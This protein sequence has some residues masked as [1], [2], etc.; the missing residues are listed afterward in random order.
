MGIP[1]TPSTHR[2]SAGETL[3]KL[4]QRYKTTVDAFVKANHIPNP[5]LI[6]VG[7]I[8]KIPGTGTSQKA[9]PAGTSPSAVQTVPFNFQ[10]LSFLQQTSTV[11]EEVFKIEGQ[12]YVFTTSNNQTSIALRSDA[13]CFRFGQQ[14]KPVWF[15]TRDNGFPLFA[16]RPNKLDALLSDPAALGNAL[17]PAKA[18]APFRVFTAKQMYAYE[19][20]FQWFEPLADHYRELIW[21]HPGTETKSSPAYQAYK[22][23]TWKDIVDFSNVDRWSISYGRKNEGDWKHNKKDGADGFLLVSLEGYPYWADAIGQ[24]PFAVD[25]YKSNL[26]ELG[27]KDKAILQTV[28]TGIKHGDGSIFFTTKDPT[29]NYDNFMVLRGALWAANNHS[30]TKTETEVS[31]GYGER[32]TLT[33]ISVRYQ[34]RDMNDLKK[35]ITHLPLS[36]YGVWRKK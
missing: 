11:T 12:D 31:A 19:T 2:V 1:S 21:V 13:S 35:P 3:S 6:Q 32:V 23:F 18:G 34:F 8:L 15:V 9:K 24:I 30:F 20:G 10:T 16:L 29:N 36:K 7:Q 27:D 28:K 22:H 14:I 4:A 5:D 17:S 26:E 33:K 25:T